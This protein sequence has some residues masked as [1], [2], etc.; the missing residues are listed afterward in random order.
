MIARSEMAPPIIT[1]GDADVVTTGIAR[2]VTMVA[3]AGDRSFPRYLGRDAW[4]PRDRARRSQAGRR[5]R[6][7]RRRWARPPWLEAFY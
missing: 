5:V 2:L 6:M 7:E 1:G 4:R 3:D